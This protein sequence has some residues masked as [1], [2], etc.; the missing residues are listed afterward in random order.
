MEFFWFGNL[1]SS[2]GCKQIYRNDDKPL[3]RRGNKIL[4]GIAAYNSLAFI[5]AKIFYVWKNQ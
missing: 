2:S 4:L 3:Y 1:F 5:G